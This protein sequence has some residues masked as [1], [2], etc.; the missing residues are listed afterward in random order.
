MP[1]KACCH[2]SVTVMSESLQPHGLQHAR[3]PCP[4][5]SP[6]VC[7]NSSPLSWWCHPTISSSVTRFSFCPRFSP[8]SGSFT[9]SQPFTSGSQSIGASA[10]AS[11]SVLPVNIQGWILLGLTGLIFFQSKGLSRVFSSHSS[12]ASILQRSAFLMIQLS[13]TC[14]TTGK[15]MTLTRQTFGGKVMALFFNMLTRFVIAFL[16][17]SK[18]LLISWLQLPC[19]VSLE[20]KKQMSLFLLFPYL[21]AMKWWDQMPWS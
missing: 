2:C 17:K 18:H 20:P 5:L 15:T 21:F 4:S 7:S 19:T 13:H 9:M 8:T 16:P 14:V 3:L 10:S 11:A 12:K 1:S 6:G